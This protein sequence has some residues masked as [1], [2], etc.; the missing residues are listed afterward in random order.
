MSRQEANTRLDNQLSRKNCQMFSTGFNSG[1]R[2]GRSTRVRLSGTTRSLARCH[3]ARSI[4][5]PPWAPEPQPARLPPGAGSWPAYRIGAAPGPR[6][7]PVEGRSPRRCRPNS[8]ADR[9]GRG[10]GCPVGPSAGRSCSSGRPGPRPATTARSGCRSGGPPG[11]SP[12]WRGDFFKKLQHLRVLGIVTGARR[13]LAIAERAQF[14]AQRRLADRDPKLL[15]DPQGQILQAPANHA[16]DRRHRPTLDNVHQGLALAV[17]QLA[18]VAR[19]LAVDQALRAA[20]V[21]PHN[22]A[23]NALQPNAANPRCPG[24]G[25]AIIDLGQGQQPPTMTR[26]PGRFRE[27]PKL[28]RVIVRT[29]GNPWPHGEPPVRPRESDSLQSEKPGMSQPSR[30][31]V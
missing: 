15:P 22:P 11:S 23:P 14:P 16:V 6:P 10:A 4:S 1:A 28:G 27:G 26:I 30:G 7:Y 25:A 5:M 8:S 18:G 3:P 13:E 17:V 2:A 20:R 29:K 12:R 31:L 24:P 19:G 21:E 9:A